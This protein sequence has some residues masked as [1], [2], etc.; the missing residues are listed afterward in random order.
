MHFLQIWIVPARPGLPP[1][2]DQKH[3]D[4][5]ARGVS[6]GSPPPTR[7]RERSG[8]SRTSPVRLAPAAGGIRGPPYGARG[9]TRGSTSPEGALTLGDASLREGDGAAV[10]AVETMSLRA[11]EP[12]EI[13]L[14]DLA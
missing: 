11:T 5:A 8:C 12:A 7:T 1:R 2:Y 10:S 3:F 6:S 9:V 4:A 14:F 13:L